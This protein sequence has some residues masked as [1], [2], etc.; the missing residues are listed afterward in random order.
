MGCGHRPIVTRVHRL[1][2]V[3]CF[4]AAAF[5]YDDAV[6]A[7]TE[8]VD[9]Q[10]TNSDLTATFNVRWPGFQGYYMFLT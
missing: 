7:H 9:Y 8:R 2:H 4:S 3:E 6:R 1:K 10:I 5:S